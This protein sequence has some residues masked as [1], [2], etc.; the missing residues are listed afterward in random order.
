[1]MVVV[2]LSRRRLEAMEE[3]LTARL[4]GEIED[5]EGKVEDYHAALQ[6][7]RQEIRKREKPV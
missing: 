1:M 6:W 3:A 7:V 2:R 5:V 4:A